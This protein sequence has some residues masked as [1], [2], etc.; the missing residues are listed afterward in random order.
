MPNLNKIMLI[1]NIT[2]EPALSYLPSQTAVI[3]FGLAIN[4]NWTSKDGEKRSEVC[5]VE[6]IAFGKPAETLNKYVSKG[7]PLFVEGRLKFD[8]WTAKDGTKRNKLRVLIE[9]FQF[10]GQKQDAPQSQGGGENPE[11]YQGDGDDSVPF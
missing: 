2:R 6:C 3:E 7:N 10:L 11:F 5:Y 1:G 4:R 9:N 8:S